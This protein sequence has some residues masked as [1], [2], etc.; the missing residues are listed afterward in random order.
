MVTNHTRRDDVEELGQDRCHK[1][2]VKHTTSPA[3]QMMSCP[4]GSRMVVMIEQR[5]VQGS[6]VC[7]L[8]Y[9]KYVGIGGSDGDC[10]CEMTVVAHAT[11]KVFKPL[12]TRAPQARVGRKLWKNTQCAVVDTHIIQGTPEEQHE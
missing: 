11:C 8:C 10:D 9:Y 5:K 2:D 1:D 7:K 12:V 4:C 6:G 3:E